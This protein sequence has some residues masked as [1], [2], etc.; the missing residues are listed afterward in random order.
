MR[1]RSRELV[2]RFC[3][4]RH[5][6]YTSWGRMWSLITLRSVA[7][8]TGEICLLRSSWW[9][10]AQWYLFL[11]WEQNWRTL[12][13]WLRSQFPE[14]STWGRWNTAQDGNWYSTPS[15]LYINKKDWDKISA[16]YTATKVL[17][18]HHEEK[19]GNKKY[20][21]ARTDLSF[22]LRCIDLA[23]SF[24]RGCHCNGRLLD[25]GGQFLLNSIDYHC[26]QVTV[27]RSKQSRGTWATSWL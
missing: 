25:S 23:V 20:A 18:F 6:T 17:L 26:I 15:V 21:R 22:W 3:M 7:C 5:R 9:R 8:T 27:I 10:G 2:G 16:R 19:S 13:S 11:S 12:W 4:L 24:E 14:S 1:K